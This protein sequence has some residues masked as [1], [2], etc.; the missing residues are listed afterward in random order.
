MSLG[1]FLAFLGVL[2]Y[3]PWLIDLSRYFW[4]YLCTGKYFEKKHSYST[5][6]EPVGSTRSASGQ[7]A[8]PARAHLGPAAKA[9][10][11]NL[12]VRA[13][14]GA[15]L[16]PYLSQGETGGNFILDEGLLPSSR[17]K[18]PREGRRLSCRSSIP[19]ILT[20]AW[21]R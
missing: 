7:P 18:L 15:G 2:E 16:R 12:C 14:A 1:I 11:A 19:C 4:I 9:A 13:K 6:A 21:T 5:W 3:F 8:R 17:M 20:S 10:A